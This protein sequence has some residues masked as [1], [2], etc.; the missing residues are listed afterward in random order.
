[1]VEACERVE[2]FGNLN[3]LSSTLYNVRA[4]QR[5]LWVAYRYLYSFAP[6]MAM[7][8]S[9]L[10]EDGRVLFSS[11]QLV[12]FAEPPPG[13]RWPA[14]DVSLG[15]PALL[16]LPLPRAARRAL[17]P[18]LQGALFNTAYCAVQCIVQAARTGDTDHPLY[19]YDQIR[20]RLHYYD[21][22]PLRRLKLWLLRYAITH[23]R[24]GMWLMRK[25][26]GFRYGHDKVDQLL[27]DRFGH[28]RL[29]RL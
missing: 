24:A 18:K 29:S 9:A 6:Q 10:G 15:F 7:L 16:E 23:P 8:L 22:S 21:R 19:L 5:Q 26:Y 2:S 3:F 13:Q 25:F 12:H 11:E 1:V 27:A 4:M 28:D 17:A 20:A 14:A